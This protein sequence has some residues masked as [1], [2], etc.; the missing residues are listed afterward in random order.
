M[1]GGLTIDAEVLRRWLGTTFA[2]ELVSCVP[3]RLLVQWVTVE[4]LTAEAAT[5][6]SLHLTDSTFL[7]GVVI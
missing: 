3:V 6:I 1:V 4:N 7:H 2:G 5:L